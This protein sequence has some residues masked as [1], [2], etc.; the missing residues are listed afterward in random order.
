LVP[1]NNLEAQAR[2]AWLQIARQLLERFSNDVESTRLQSGDACTNHE[3]G[4]RA[5]RRGTYG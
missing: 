3:L 2:E 5:D 1:A 4:Q